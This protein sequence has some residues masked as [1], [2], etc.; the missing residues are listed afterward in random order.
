MF[1]AADEGVLY[2][3]AGSR[4]NANSKAAT[5][6]ASNREA[7]PTTGHCQAE[8]QLKVRGK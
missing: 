6:T 3:I 2:L 1:L 8:V 7:S 4:T 5:L